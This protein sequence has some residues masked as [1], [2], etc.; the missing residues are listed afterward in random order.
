MKVRLEDMC[1]VLYTNIRAIKNQQRT[2]IEGVMLGVER[3]AGMDDWKSK[4][5][6]W[7]DEES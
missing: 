2:E 4:R 5:G 7:M 6:R 1:C 3:E